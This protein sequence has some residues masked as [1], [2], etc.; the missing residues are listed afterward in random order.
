[1]GKYF[2]TDG[3]R[4]EANVQLTAEHAFAIGRYIGWYF[5]QNH[6]ARIVIG[7]DTRRSGDMLEHA[8]ASG[9]AESGADA[10]LMQVTTTPSVA[11]MV[12]K[13][14]FDCGVMISASHNPFYDNGIKLIGSNGQ[15]IEA[16]IEQAIEQYIDAGTPEIPRAMR[17]EIGAVIAYPKGVDDYI[18]YLAAAAGHSYAGCRIAIDCANGSTSAIAAKVLEKAGAEVQVI[19][20]S[21][22]G[23]NI[24]RDCGSTHMESLQQFVR[25][26][27]MHAGFAY[28][29]DGDR[30][31]AV[32]EN[33]NVIDGDLIMYIGAK[34][35]RE[36]GALEGNTLVT[37]VMSNIGLYKALDTA[38]IRY[39]QTAVG[40]KYV[41]EC[42]F[43][44][45]YSI[46]GEQSGH[47]IL[48]KYA[49]TGDGILTSLMLLD[50]MAAEQ[51]SLAELSSEVTIFPQLLKNVR[52]A[53][54]NTAREN[55]RMLEAVE[56]VSRKLGSDGRVL[57]RESGT[58]PLIRVM[59][60]AKT[61]AVCRECVDS[62][63]QVM[64][65]EG[66]VLD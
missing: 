25:E 64:Q 20:N 36:Q 24:N 5:G 21:P 28:D 53:D 52:V 11:Y 54:K 16:S 10:Y 61:D 26:N 47:I 3:F 30:C 43:S 56:A 41:A 18:E 7:K 32:D 14:Q 8:L 1:M 34:Y 46:G 38:G 42:M 6:R 33:G 50:A 12:R 22:D 57:V 55:A 62:I 2:G 51:A 39:E 19:H 44:N 65:E 45:G 49:K 23:I 17:E 15:K 27:H 48:A 59:V 40:D 35:L 37:T 31:L 9:I 63:V 13:E 66:L 60:E 4:G 58:E 29:G